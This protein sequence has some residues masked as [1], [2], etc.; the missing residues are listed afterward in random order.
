MERFFTILGVISFLCI[1]IL[2]VYVTVYLLV[3]GVTC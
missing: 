1:T 3:E 2:L